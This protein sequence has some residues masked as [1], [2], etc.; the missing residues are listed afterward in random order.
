MLNSSRECYMVNP[1]VPELHLPPCWMSW[2]GGRSQAPLGLMVPFMIASSEQEVVCSS[3]QRCVRN[4][5]N[6]HGWDDEEDD[7]NVLI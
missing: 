1:A 2:G 4:V 7:D 5:G 6:P 3:G